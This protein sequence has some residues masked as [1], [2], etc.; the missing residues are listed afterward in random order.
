M[1]Q[2]MQEP[3]NQL[4]NRDVPTVVGSRGGLYPRWW[5]VSAFITGILAIL[6]L[7]VGPYVPCSATS[8]LCH[9]TNW[10]SILQVL[11]VWAVFVLVWFLAMIFGIGS[12]EIPRRERSSLAEFV[13]SLSEFGPLHSLLL[14]FGT[15]ALVSLIAMWVLDS[16]T[17]LAFAF[18][19]IVVFVANASLFFR[20]P[21][22]QRRNSLIGYGVLGLLGLTLTLIY[23]LQNIAEQPFFLAEGLLIVTGIWSIFWR[24]QPA[25]LPSAQDQLDANIAQ[26]TSPLYVLR[27]IWPFNRLFPNRPF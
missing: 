18:C 26:A 25:Q 14:I 19:S 11:V 27:S 10:Y 13:R 20:R 3:P 7:L 17:P 15:L 23:R 22:Y 1:G 21:V 16:T 9:F 2:Q 5:I 6:L 12:I 24:P 4:V 8:N